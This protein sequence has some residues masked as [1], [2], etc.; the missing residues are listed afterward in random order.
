MKKVTILLFSLFSLFAQNNSTKDDNSGSI[1]SNTTQ[2]SDL[3]SSK[4]E[5]NLAKAI[6]KEK[7][8]QKEQ[9]FYQGEEYNLSEHEVDPSSLEKIK[10]IEPEY[11]YEMLEF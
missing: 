8:F 10:V 7:K 9:K 5:A 11:D 1:E 2:T 4:L 6:A 3:N